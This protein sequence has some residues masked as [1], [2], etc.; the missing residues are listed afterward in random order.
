[1][2]NQYHRESDFNKSAEAIPVS[3]YEFKPTLGMILGSGWS[4]AVTERECVDMLPF[5]A[6][7]GLGDSTVKGHAGEIRLIEDNG[8]RAVVFC[9]RRHYYEGAGWEPVVTPIEIM[10]R[11]GVTDLLLTNAAGGINSDFKAGDFMLITDHIN[12]IGLNPLIGPLREG[13][14]P[15]FPDQSELYNKVKRERI[16]AIADEIGI[17]VKD[18]I[19]CYTSGPCYETPA[20]IRAYKSMGADAVGMSTVPEAIVAGAM[21]MNIAAVSCITNMA[22]GISP[23]PLTH[24][25]VIEVTNEASPKMAALINRIIKES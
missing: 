23:V 14:G 18:G 10:H 6:I 4:L 19:Y 11:I 2:R 20:E 13:R 21:G 8:K 9:G 16:R 17:A 22:A 7:P 25:E 5:S 12:T 3:W 15:R 24:G 1:M